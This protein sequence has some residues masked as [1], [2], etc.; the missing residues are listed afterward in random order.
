MHFRHIALTEK[1]CLL[2][3]ESTRQKVKRDIPRIQTQTL[4][5]LHCSER[6]I[7]CDK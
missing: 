1:D 7:V 2:S 4:R 6:M 5:I 3:V